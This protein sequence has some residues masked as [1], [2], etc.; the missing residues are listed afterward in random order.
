MRCTSHTPP[1]RVTRPPRGRPQRQLV[2]YRGSYDAF[3]K[4]ADDRA[5]N[6]RREYDAYVEKRA[7]M[8]EFIDKFRCSA[9][10]AALVQSRVKASERE[11][12]TIPLSL[13]LP[14]WTLWR[15]RGFGGDELDV[16]RMRVSGL[17]G[18]PSS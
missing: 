5:K 2:N 10:R 13:S 4:T 1:R 11:R 6:Q 15:P 3:I 12:A 16:A 18:R 14:P 9:S 17:A 7:H 8:Q